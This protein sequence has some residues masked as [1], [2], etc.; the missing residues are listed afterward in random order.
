M[1]NSFWLCDLTRAG[2]VCGDCQTG[3]C[4]NSKKMRDLSLVEALED[5]LLS[6]SLL[7]AYRSEERL[8]ILFS[9]ASVSSSVKWGYFYLPDSVLCVIQILI[10]HA[11]YPMLDS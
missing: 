7:G 4:H 10:M 8:L 5:R 1:A 2:V 6:F 9:W 3:T 11:V